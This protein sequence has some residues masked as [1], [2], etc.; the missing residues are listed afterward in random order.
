MERLP[1][2]HP[3][4]NPRPA[5]PPHPHT[6][7]PLSIYFISYTSLLQKSAF[8]AHALLPAHIHRPI[9]PTHI[10]PPHIRT[11]TT[12]SVATTHHHQVTLLHTPTL[13]TTTHLTRYV[14]CVSE[15]LSSVGSLLLDLRLGEGQKHLLGTDEALL[16]PLQARPHGL[17]G[18]DLLRRTVASH[19]QPPLVVL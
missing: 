15:T 13:L 7:T 8:P 2:T 14:R 17:L 3:P 10:H 19:P 5:C 16:L 9:S 11:T 4:S 1:P 6:L 18:L 12:T